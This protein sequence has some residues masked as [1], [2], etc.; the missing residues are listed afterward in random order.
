MNQRIERKKSVIE[1]IDFLYNFGG[2]QKRYEGDDFDIANDAIIAEISKDEDGK[3]ETNT[4]NFVD[5]KVFEKVQDYINDVNDKLDYLAFVKAMVEKN[6]A[7]EMENTFGTQKI[8]VKTFS[9]YEA[10]G[11]FE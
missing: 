10:L 3:R 6:I 5:A 7:K 2:N 1:A 11:S 9:S 8:K 4:W